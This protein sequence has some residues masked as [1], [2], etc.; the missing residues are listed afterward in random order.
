MSTTHPVS[1]IIETRPLP[2]TLDADGVA[3]VGYT[4][5]TLD[6]VIAAFV[7][8]ATAEEIVYQYPSLDLPD[9]YSVIGYYLRHRSEIDQYLRQRQKQA[10]V[11]RKRNESH[12]DPYG[13][14]ERLLAR[15]TNTG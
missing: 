13:I 14:R 1:L 6:T 8:G 5:V 12:H 11:I 15:K 2:L 9:V 7:E 3:R 10:S 4:R